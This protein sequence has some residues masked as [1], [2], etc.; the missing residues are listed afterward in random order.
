MSACG[1]GYKP[2]S[3]PTELDL[4]PEMNTLLTRF[5][6]ALAMLLVVAPAAI[7]QPA[8]PAAYPGPRFPGGSDSLRALVGYSPAAV[9][10]RRGVRI[11]LVP[12]LARLP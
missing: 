7:G 4:A 1:V 11:R 9:A 6:A 2:I 10:A 5:I 8:A 12:K 3:L